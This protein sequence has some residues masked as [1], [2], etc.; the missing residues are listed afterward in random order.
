MHRPTRLL[1]FSSLALALVAEAGSAQCY[2]VPDNLP[3]SGSGCNVI[4]FGDATPTSATWS[5]QLYHT[6]VTQADLNN[7]VGLVTGLSFAPCGSGVR[8]FT[9]LTV[10]MGHCNL[11]TMSTTFASNFTTPGVTVLDVRDF[12]W[13]N[14]VGVW[15]RLPLQTPFVYVPALGDLLIELWC[16]GVGMPSGTAGMQTMAR[17]RMYARSWVGTP[18]PTGTLGSSA[19]VKLEVCLGTAGTTTFGSGCPGSNLQSPALDYAGSSK[20]GQTLTINVTKAAGILPFG[21]IFG[22]TIAPPFPLVLDSI[23]MTGC[24]LYTD[25][26]FSL[27]GVTLTGGA[28]SVSIPI[29]V[30]STLVGTV[31]FNQAGLI[32]TPANRFG[33][34]TTNGGNLIVGN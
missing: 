4:P 22:T 2:G 8:Q 26:L 9:R 21:M 27:P 10:R 34:I 31:L 1:S 33:V 19:A 29:P 6:L 12:Q 18:P 24:R 28:G 11:G 16:E 14:T 5:N 3:G 7:Q 25:S 30:T 17:P 23:G 32:D 13:P 20:L 15:N